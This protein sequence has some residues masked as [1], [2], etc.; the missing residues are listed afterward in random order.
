M[1]PSL[2][3]E[4]VMRIT[5]CSQVFSAHVK[6]RTDDELDA[7]PDQMRTEPLAPVPFPGSSVTSGAP[8]SPS[9]ALSW[10]I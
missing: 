10:K 2:A 3:E 9:V 1:L 6:L 7:A 5:T 8:S 4:V